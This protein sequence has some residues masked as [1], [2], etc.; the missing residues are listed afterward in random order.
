MKKK[1]RNWVS[2]P[3][4]ADSSSTGFVSAW[5]PC[6]CSM[7]RNDPYLITGMCAQEYVCAWAW[8]YVWAWAQEYVCAHAQEYVWACEQA[9]SC[10]WGPGHRI[11]W[12]RVIG[13]WE[14]FS[15]AAGI[16]L[17]PLEEKVELLN[18]ESFIFVFVYKCFVCMYA[19]IPYVCLVPTE[20][21]RGHWVP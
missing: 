15:S 11:L 16:K 7:L 6:A 20:V 4:E 8:E 13:P 19:C 1:E 12:D 3:K 5:N 2:F 18:R 10:S 17:G 14:P 9:C 21:R